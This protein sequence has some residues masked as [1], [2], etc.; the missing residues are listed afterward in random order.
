[1]AIM[2]VAVGAVFATI[3]GFQASA[4]I[5]KVIATL[6]NPPQTVSTIEAE[7]QPWRDRLLAV[8]SARAVQQRSRT[9]LSLSLTVR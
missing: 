2:L 7:T 4:M 1:M 3:F 5:Q 9:T 6:R 8:G